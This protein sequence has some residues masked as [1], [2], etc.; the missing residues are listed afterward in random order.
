MRGLGDYT[1]GL[2]GEEEEM[3]V[4]RLMVRSGRDEGG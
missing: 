2:E 1:E 4:G 3:S